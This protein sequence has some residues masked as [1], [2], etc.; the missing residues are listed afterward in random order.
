MI[1]LSTGKD[2]R[3]ISLELNNQNG[4]FIS[5]IL[6][7]ILET[8]NP[9]GRVSFIRDIILASLFSRSLSDNRFSNRERDLLFANSN[10]LKIQDKFTG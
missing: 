7:E 1:L 10:N 2:F 3:E 8:T 9:I 4:F 6:A 5:R